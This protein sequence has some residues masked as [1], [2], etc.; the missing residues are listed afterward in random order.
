M[1]I[2]I[3][4]DVVYFCALSVPE[5]LWEH[6]LFKVNVYIDADARSV[7]STVAILWCWASES[8]VGIFVLDF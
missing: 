6:L 8:F 5:T 1:A 2:A 7:T 4:V 3:V